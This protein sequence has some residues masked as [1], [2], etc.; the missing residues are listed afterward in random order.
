MKT[1]GSSRYLFP[2]IA[3]TPMESPHTTT[4]NAAQSR[5]LPEIEQLVTLDYSALTTGVRPQSVITPARRTRSY[6]RRHVDK[7]EARAK[8][9]YMRLNEKYQQLQASYQKLEK[10]CKQQKTQI[11]SLKAQLAR[12]VLH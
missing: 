7:R 4:D 11:K 12:H 5:Q 8:N 6:D 1:L 9:R 3:G 2:Y 10:E